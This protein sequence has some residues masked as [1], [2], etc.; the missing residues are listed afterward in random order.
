MKG[1]RTPTPKEKIGTKCDWGVREREDGHKDEGRRRKDEDRER[2]GGQG[3][4]GA[5]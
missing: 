4:E 5:T 1:K 3:L 2:V